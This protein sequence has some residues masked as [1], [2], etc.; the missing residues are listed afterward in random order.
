[1]ILP[2][3]N[4]FTRRKT[5]PN[6]TLSTRSHM[7]LPVIEIGTST[8]KT[9]INLNRAVRVISSIVTWWYVLLAGPQVLTFYRGDGSF[10]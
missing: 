1:M 8:A 7:Y 4:R 5:C 9:K 2:E 3:E 10:L 6:S